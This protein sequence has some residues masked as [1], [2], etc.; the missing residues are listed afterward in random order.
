MLD[1]NIMMPLD[2]LSDER[3]LY[4]IMPYCDGGE[5]FERLDMNERFG[6]EE[7]RYWMTQVLNVSLQFK[8]YS[9]QYNSVPVSSHNY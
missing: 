7:A 1:T 2:L 3:H 8:Q 4:S 6:E 5:L 9:V